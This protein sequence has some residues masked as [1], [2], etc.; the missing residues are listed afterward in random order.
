[1]YLIERVTEKQ[2]MQQ[3]APFGPGVPGDVAARTDRVEVWGSSFDDNGADFCEFRLFDAQG[4]LI[5]V[6]RVAG[7]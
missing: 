2:A 1:M 7:Y 5:A 3:P 6:N 4:N